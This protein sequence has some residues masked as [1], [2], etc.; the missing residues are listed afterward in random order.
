[1]NNVYG[2]NLIPDNDTERIA[3][4]ERYQIFNS[5]REKAFDSICELACELFSCPI[6]HISFLNADTEFIKAEVGLNGLQ[7]VSR[8]VGFCS[9]AILQPDLLLVEDTHKHE[10]FVN[11][12]YV[13]DKL[14]IRFYAG[15]PIISPDG[16]IIGTLCLIDTEPRSLTEK[17]KKLLRKLADVAMEQTQLRFDNLSLLQQRDEFIAIA[18]HEMRTPVTALK[19]AIQVLHTYQDGPADLQKAMI[20][21]ANRSV[22]KL[23]YLVNDLFDTSR[24]AA[25]KYNLEKTFFDI[26]ELI[27]NCC[28]FVKVSGKHELDIEGDLSVQVFADKEKIEQV[29]VNLVENAMKYAPDSLVILVRV[30]RLAEVLRIY[31][32]DKGPGIGSDQLP[33]IFKRY[34]RSE[35]GTPQA[36]LGLGL[37]ICA[38]IVKQ[39]GGEIGVESEQGLGSTFWF[40][41]PMTA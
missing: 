37:Y 9:V 32:T 21:Q 12:P 34:F 11:H 2:I 4:L 13:T 38:E 27:S 28:D 35:N 17:E 25:R 23:T 40:T 30:H 41:I 16:Y 7:Y 22:N 31:V 39:H 18:S 8:S 3:A 15:A 14:R 10:L 33:H 19:A 20:E 26:G 5:H 6:S 29:L 24:L 1:M 36:G